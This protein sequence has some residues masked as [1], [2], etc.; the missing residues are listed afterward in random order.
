[1]D[2]LSLMLGGL[3]VAVAVWAAYRAMS[4]T[5]EIRQLKREQYYLDGRVKRTAEDIRDAVQPLR[6]QLAN[7]TI[8]KPVSRELILAGRPY[9]DI[10]AADAE[11]EI[12]KSGG[13]ASAQLMVVD[14]RTAKEYA[15]KHLPGARLVPLEELDGRYRRDIPDTVEKV[16]VYCGSGERSRLACDFLG[17]QGYTNVY[18]I[19][20][21]LRGWRGPTE[22]EGE[23]T[24]IK[25]ESKR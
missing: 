24:F 23:L 12:A 3:S 6:W 5:K 2:V 13:F 1:M 18:N 16:F 10:S 25:F 7:L 4:L 11:R 14:V 22:G 21:G 20:D 17:Q 9:L 15:A 8:Q 19:Q